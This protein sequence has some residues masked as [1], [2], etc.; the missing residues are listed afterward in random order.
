VLEATK[1]F[2]G[3][4]ND[5]KTQKQVT[6]ATTDALADG[7]PKEKKPRA[8]RGQM[9]IATYSNFDQ[10]NGKTLKPG[11]TVIFEEG[12]KAISF[13]VTADGLEAHSKDKGAD[14]LLKRLGINGTRAA[15]KCYSYDRRNLGST[16]FP[17]VKIGDMSS[18]TRLVLV[19]FLF[20]EGAEAVDLKMFN[21]HWKHI[22]P[23]MIGI[24]EP[25]A[26]ELEA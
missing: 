19:L 9:E 4:P 14:A 24:N 15:R 21:R 26:E 7:A 8:L 23:E 5:G 6:K 13:T 3:K 18:L 11:N 16:D 10:L 12:G 20:N 25:A 1:K 2:V 17:T 22:T